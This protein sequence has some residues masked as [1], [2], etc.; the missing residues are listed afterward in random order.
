MNET[1][2]TGIVN[3]RIREL[4]LKNWLQQQLNTDFTF[5]LIFG[6]ASF[7]RYFR[8]TC[9]QRTMIAVDAPPPME[10]CACFIAVDQ[11][12]SAAGVHVPK[13]LAADIGQG[14]LLQE[15]FGDQQLLPLLTAETAG[16]YYLQALGALPALMSVRATRHGPLPHFDE[17][18]QQREVQLFD[19][20]LIA[21]HLG[22]SLT[23]DEQQ[24]VAAT[25]QLVIR[26]NL[27]QPQRGVHRDYHSRN[28][29]VCQDGQLGIID[30]QDA[31][32]GPITY[33]I[34][35][36]L[37]DC[38][39]KWPAEQV[40]A[41]LERGYRILIRQQQI[42]AAVTFKEFKRWFDWCGMQRHI[43]VAGIFARLYHR[44]GKARYL[45]DIPLTLDY[46]IEVGAL[47]N[48]TRAFS[49]WLAERIKPA[50]METL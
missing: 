17:A 20:W 3:H 49:A 14:F 25:Q 35:S 4:M 32:L 2:N 43:K 26:E 22:L 9:G 5:R 27:A 45:Q 16:D 33:D 47:Y 31:V 50:F 21:R 19:D 34:V 48:E 13:I 44:D 6:D 38:Y 29:M 8:V 37:R 28:L 24:L 41:W 12:F 46:L 11:A 30:F 40:S 42:S 1:P 39:I 15:D 7:R 36:L 18:M 23:A 10:D